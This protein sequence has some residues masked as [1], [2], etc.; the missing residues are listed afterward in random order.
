MFPEVDFWTITLSD[1]K[2]IVGERISYSHGEKP[3]NHEFCG[4][5]FHGRETPF[6]LEEHDIPIRA[7]KYFSKYICN[8]IIRICDPKKSLLIYGRDVCVKSEI[9]IKIIQIKLSDAL[10]FTKWQK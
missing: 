1:V 8:I 9:P 2:T 3:L 10:Y 6:T 7:F 5:Y 4:I